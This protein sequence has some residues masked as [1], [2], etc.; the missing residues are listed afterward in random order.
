[1]AERELAAEG[2][3]QE[4]GFVESGKRVIPH[5]TNRHREVFR[6]ED[7]VNLR[8]VESRPRIRAPQIPLRVVRHEVWAVLLET[9]QL[10]VVAPTPR[11]KARYGA[12]PGR[13][14]AAAL[15]SL[16]FPRHRLTVYGPPSMYNPVES[17]A[18]VDQST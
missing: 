4:A 10:C 1:M 15:A 5:L 6:E 18:T 13:R 12:I 14:R 11:R 8:Y 3:R 17:L 16:I 7:Y 2:V 9:E